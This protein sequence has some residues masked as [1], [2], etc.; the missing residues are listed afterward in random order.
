[1]KKLYLAYPDRLMVDDDDA[2][3]GAGRV[4]P[5]RRAGLRA[6]RGR[7]RSRPWWRA[8][9]AGRHRAGRR[10]VRAAALGGAEAV[11]RAAGLAV[12]P[13][14]RGSTWC[15]SPA[16]RA[17]RRSLAAQGL[18]RPH[19]TGPAPTTCISSGRTS[20][21]VT[22]TSSA[23]TAAARASDRAAPCAG[24]G[25]RRRRGVSTDHC[26]SRP[27]TGGAGRAGPGGRT[28]PDPGGSA[29]S[30]PGCRWSTRACS[31]GACRSSAGWT[32]P[33][34]PRAAL[35]ADGVRRGGPA[36]M[37]TWWCS[38]W[39]DPPSRRDELHSRCDHS[40]YAGLEVTAA[41][42]HDQPGRRR[43]R[44]RKPADPR[45]GRGRFVR[46]TRRRQGRSR[47]RSAKAPTA[48]EHRD[49]QGGVSLIPSKRWASSRSTTCG[50]ERLVRGSAGGGN[51]RLTLVDHD[52]QGVDVGAEV[53]RP[54]G[55]TQRRRPP[56]VGGGLY[57]ER[58]ADIRAGV[59]LGL[60]DEVAHD[61]RRLSGAGQQAPRSEGCSR[62]SAGGP[63]CQGN[64]S[65]GSTAAWW[66]S[67]ASVPLEGQS[68]YSVG[69]CWRRSRPPRAASMMKPAMPSSMG[70]R[71]AAMSTCVVPRR[72]GGVRGPASN[73]LFERC[74]H[75]WLYEPNAH[76]D[77]G[78]GGPMSAPP[79]R[80]DPPPA[81]PGVAPHRRLR[82]HRRGRGRA[83]GPRRL[84]RRHSLR[85]PPGPGRGHRPDRARTRRRGG[86]GGRRGRRR[87]AGRG[88][89]VDEVERRLGGVDRAGARCRHH[90]PR[91]LASTS[92]PRRL[93]PACTA[94]RA[95]GRSWSRRPPPM[96][97]GGALVKPTPQRGR[98]ASSLG[99]R[100]HQGAVDAMT[101]ILAKG[102][103]ARRHRQR[104]RP[105]DRQRCSRGTNPGG[106]ST[107]R[108]RTCHRSSASVSRPTSRSSPISPVPARWSTARSS[109]ST[110]SPDLPQPRPGVTDER[111]RN[112]PRHPAPPAASGALMVR[113]LADARARRP[114]RHARPGRPPARRPDARRYAAEHG[115][116]LR[117][118]EMVVDQRSGR[119]RY[120]RDRL[121]ESGGSTMP[122]PTTPGTWSLGPTEG[123]HRR[124]A[125]GS[126]TPTRCRRRSGCHGPSCHLRARRGRAGGVDRLVRC[127]RHTAVLA[128]YFA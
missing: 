78:S 44:R 72:W 81:S 14:R 96:R 85:G 60:R 104:R 126:T 83:A 47:A 109:T 64:S 32:R 18:R 111:P 34:V 16:R 76:I 121:A 118:V 106:P 51:R 112:H 87:R 74:V 93:R 1:M 5:H 27:R 37:P 100:G 80:P 65:A 8:V 66:P 42:R 101:M 79:P 71:P 24:P 82:W 39:H 10:T 30:R 20:R 123:L 58:Y 31:T 9:A 2:R 23:P 113:A 75:I 110:A 15:T 19:P 50:L 69:R 25:C 86:D 3:P 84:R 90:A 53:D 115:V 55:P 89:D 40:P 122:G 4:A 116:A 62:R 73:P 107:S 12:R 77:P 7:R 119:R 33:P 97:H 117:P 99:V 35:R 59:A 127:P 114:R 94:P 61:G 41:G 17:C 95:P 49:L 13:T 48:A 88:G 45:P 70:R 120:R 63:R 92:P 21:P 36:S 11:R 56:A 98:L 43:G 68:R 54:G 28:S 91:P 26:P 102:R 29:V 103:G 125:R 67:S 57:D 22:R 38:T 52:L 105:R 124:G 46:R 128:T 108:R 6:R